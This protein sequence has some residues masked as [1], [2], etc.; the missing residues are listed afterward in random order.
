MATLNQP[1][2]NLSKNDLQDLMVETDNWLTDLNFLSG[3]IKFYWKVTN[4][5]L[6]GID[7]ETTDRVALVQ[8]DLSQLDF[9]THRIRAEV[10]NYRE[11]LDLQLREVKSAEG[12]WVKDL[13]QELKLKINNLNKAARDFKD[14]VFDIAE[15]VY[16]D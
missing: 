11:E 10:L 6:K 5:Y 1:V 16:G 14:D 15:D 13:H 12:E 2:H 3:E 7:K 8:K 9:T 4:N